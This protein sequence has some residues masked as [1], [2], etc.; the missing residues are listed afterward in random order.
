VTT[1]VID[2]LNEEDFRR[3]IEN[4]LREGKA[5]AAIERLRSLLGPYAR[6][7]GILPERFLTIE[8]ADL[9]LSGWDALGEAVCQHDRPGR[10]VTALS[11]AFGWP[12]EEGPQPDAEGCFH[13][14]VETSYFNDDAFPF[15]Q[16]GREDLLEGYSFYDCTWAGD[17]EATDSALSLDGIDDL[18][19][20]LAELEARLLASAE[21][22]EDGIRA[23]SLGSCLLSALLFQAVSDQIGR[24]GLPRPLCVMAGSNG[25]YPYFDAPV[26]GIPEDARKAAEAEAAGASQAIPAP[27]YSSLLMT[28]IPRAKK[29]AVLVLEESEDELAN[30][31]T[32]PDSIVPAGREEEDTGHEAIPAARSNEQLDG[33]SASACNGPLLASKPDRKAWDFRELLGPPEPEPPANEQP[34]CEQ[35]HRSEPSVPATRDES[36]PRP[37]FALLEPDLQRRPQSLVSGDAP[38]AAEGPEP[39]VPSDQYSPFRLEGL[40]RVKSDEA[41]N[42]PDGFAVDDIPLAVPADLRPRMGARAWQV[43]RRFSRAFSS[44]IAQILGGRPRNTHGQQSRRRRF[45]GQ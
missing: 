37:G 6:P 18:H 24:D 17:C 26:A 20:A 31:N 35:V 45:R 42:Q 34:L 13:P 29:R 2:G 39:A 22:D 21:P 16:C 3:S 38:P 25:V 5:G 41:A 1:I 4:R 12:G 8:A 28:G 30:R 10:P 36:A 40:G 32:G 33:A 44:A 15:S 23:G 9:A 43:L 27:R 7:G 19:S 14:H 11:I